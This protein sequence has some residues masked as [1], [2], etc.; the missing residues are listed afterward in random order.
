[1]IRADKLLGRG[2]CNL[3]SNANCLTAQTLQPLIQIFNYRDIYI[4]DIGHKICNL[5]KHERR[6][7]FKSSWN[8]HLSSAIR[9]LLVDVVVA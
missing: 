2:T 7:I 6:L 9:H 5:A 1:M 3:G 4:T 8:S